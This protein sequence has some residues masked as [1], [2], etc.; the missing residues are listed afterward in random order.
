MKI[1]RREFLRFA[2]A[3]GVVAAGRSAGAETKGHVRWY[4][5]MLHS[6][7]YW[8]DGR[9]FPDQAVA[10]YKKRG[11]DFM[12]L[13]D[14]NR[15]SWA[16]D[17]W[18]VVKPTAG[19]WPPAIEQRV[20][21]AWKRDFPWAQS[22]TNA[23]G[24]TEARL[25][26][27]RELIEHFNEPGRFLL[28]PGYELTRG[29][30]K[31]NFNSARQVHINCVNFDEVQP[32]ARY[33]KLIQ[34]V[35]T[36]HTYPNLIRESHEE[37]E[38][39]MKAKGNPPH[40]VMLNHP[41]WLLYDCLPQDLVDN[42]EIRFFEVWNNSSEIEA[43]PELQKF[44]GM[45]NDRFWDV[46][47]AFRA[48]AG[49]PL[50]YGVGSDDTHWYQFTNQ[51]EKL[52]HD[53]DAWIRVKAADLTPS[54]LFEAMNRGAFYAAA[55]LDLE[56]VEFSSR[57]LRVKAQAR[58]GETLR[59]RFIVTKWNF[60]DRIVKTVRLTERFQRS[61]PIYSDTIGTTAKLVD[62]TKSGVVEG[63]YTLAEDDL[64]VRA[65]VESD[66]FSP[67]YKRKR[68][69]RVCPRFALAWTQPYRG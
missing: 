9:A 38:M 54:A 40:L 46:V 1:E 59:I 65:R 53:A 22:R 3:A 30:G 62:G 7:S 12:C 33:T 16:K 21:D 36:D 63:S 37:A 49:Q 25:T 14:H 27:Y 28:M 67:W 61:V 35:F 8:S 6:H 29:I 47:N 42:P 51:D 57:T 68:L 20:Y 24:E 69:N 43:P 60:D 55:G 15:L 19:G 44:E 66:Q 10:S 48:R 13:S 2:A 23:Q 17:A 4:K 11:Y 64:Y 34:D 56:D 50:L 31:Q 45:D 39:M 5:G 41:Q 18:R 32:S 58:P 26:P 52:V